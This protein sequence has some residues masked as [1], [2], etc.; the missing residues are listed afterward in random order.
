MELTRR[1][2][3]AALATIGITAAGVTAGVKMLESDNDEL[4]TRLRNVAEVL[5]PSSVEFTD[6]FIETY[7]AGR[8][9]SDKGYIREVEISLDTLDSYTET[10]HESSFGEISME[11]RVET[12]DSMGVDSAD[13]DPEGTDAER[14]RFY[15]VNELLYALYTSPV[16]GRLVGIE[17]PIG[18]PGGTE[19][20]T[21][22]K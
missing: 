21:V 8:E 15:L 1:D 4:N 17:N 10:L 14:I 6:E 7:I 2:A 13:P 9:H 12:L 20:Y 16:G 19:S 11:M 3:L 18:Y 22:R 5:Y